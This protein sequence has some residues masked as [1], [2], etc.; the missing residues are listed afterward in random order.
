[1]RLLLLSLIALLAVP[2]PATQAREASTNPP[3][4]TLQ[5]I[6]ADPE[7]QAVQ[8]SPTGRYLTWLAPKNQRMN[9]A[10]LDRETR[11]LRWLTDMKIESVVSHVWAKR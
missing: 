11:K 4:P 2:M 3:P 10:I 7:V 5:E 8:L 9:L 6:F 1:M